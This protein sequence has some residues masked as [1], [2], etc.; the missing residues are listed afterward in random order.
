MSSHIT[1]ARL[2]KQLRPLQTVSKFDCRKRACQNRRSQLP[3]LTSDFRQRESVNSRNATCSRCPGALVSVLSLYYVTCEYTTDR[4]GRKVECA[5]TGGREV[6]PAALIYTACA[7]K[8]HMR[9]TGAD[10][11]P[12][13]GETEAR[14][15]PSVPFSLCR[16]ATTLRIF[17]VGCYGYVHACREQRRSDNP[18]LWVVTTTGDQSCRMSHVM[19]KSERKSGLRPLSAPASRPHGLSLPNWEVALRGGAQT[20]HLPPSRCFVPSPVHHRRLH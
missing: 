13:E 9:K 12:V 8:T 7:V 10:P 18:T 1:F 4:F 2:Y 15:Q 16:S 14:A 5:S 19:S 20:R 6:H 3:I 17:P 11:C